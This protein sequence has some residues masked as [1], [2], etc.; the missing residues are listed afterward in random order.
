[1]ESESASQTKQWK[2]SNH[3]FSA[4]LTGS[5]ISGP[6]GGI[7]GDYCMSLGMDWF[8]R[9][10]LS[11]VVFVGVPGIVNSGQHLSIAQTFSR[12]D[13]YA[14]FWRQILCSMLLFRFEHNFSRLVRES[15]MQKQLVALHQRVVHEK[16][17]LQHHFTGITYKVERL[18][19]LRHHSMVCQLVAVGTSWYK[20]LQH[21]GQV[22]HKYSS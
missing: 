15:W 12:T 22:C 3:P 5:C 20:W 4:K 9:N 13:T 17:R 11:C 18:I 8:T 10:A 6:G 14:T 21:R 2:N 19:P 7:P 16:L 1:M